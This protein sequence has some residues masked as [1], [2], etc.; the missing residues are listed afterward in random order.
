MKN[1]PT[2]FQIAF[3]AL[4]ATIA[5]HGLLLINNEVSWDSLMML[6]AKNYNNMDVFKMAIFNTGRRIVYYFWI[7]F[8]KFPHPFLL[9]K[10]FSLILIW[11]ITILIYYIADF[12]FP[13]QYLQNIFIA[14]L[15]QSIPVFFMA[16]DPISSIYILTS[17]LFFS[18]LLIYLKFHQQRFG[19]KKIA[20]YVL[21]CMLL[22]FSF[23]I[24]S[25]YVFIYA[26]LF[27]LFVKEYQLTQHTNNRE[28]VAVFF[29]NIW[30]FLK[31]H[32]GLVLFPVFSFWLW[33]K[34]FPISGMARVYGNNQ[35]SFSVGNMLYHLAFSA[36]K[37]FIALPMLLV[38]LAMHNPITI[39][40]SVVVAGIVSRYFLGQPNR[41]TSFISD[42][43]ESTQQPL[44]FW[45]IALIGVVFFVAALLPYSMVSKDYGALNRNCRNGLLVGFGLVIFL[46]LAIHRLIKQSQHQ[47]WAYITLFVL[48][49]AGSNVSYIYW[50]A[51][52]VRFQKAEQLI[53]QHLATVPSTYLVMHEEVKNPMFQYFTFYEFNFMCKEAC[54]VEKYLAVDAYTKWDKQIDVFIKNTELYKPIFMFSKFN[55][56][57]DSASHIHLVSPKNT[58]FDAEKIVWH[59]WQNNCQAND[60]PMQ[61]QAE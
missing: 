38:Q 51:Y 2:F 21:V 32:G 19:I 54:G 48:F 1:Q 15:S 25:F 20:A 47:R 22:F 34:L 13:K 44:P 58:L 8:L 28:V 53:Q 42:D 5:A 6:N 49:A 46:V 7:V 61:W 18:A 27:A 11:S 16:H 41:F 26:I 59:Y 36:Y 37:I 12:F 60:Y 43:D 29:T 17:N 4:V 56:K 24:Q 30:Q 3:V 10:F 57:T 33:N 35:I 39:I 50:Q 23:E 52:Y 14:V 40:I 45:L 31:Q 9:I 55:N